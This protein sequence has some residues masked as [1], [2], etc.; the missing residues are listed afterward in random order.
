[1]DIII[2]QRISFLRRTQIM[3]KPGIFRTFKT[4]VYH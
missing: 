1:M 2:A 4:I 3:I